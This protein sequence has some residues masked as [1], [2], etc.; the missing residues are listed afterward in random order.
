MAAGVEHLQCGKPAWC[1]EGKKAGKERE[2][3]LCL[4]YTPLPCEGEGEGEEGGGRIEREGEGDHSPG[5]ITSPVHVP[6]MKWS[7]HRD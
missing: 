2:G 5:C 7:G 1:P 4:K 3:V 6:V